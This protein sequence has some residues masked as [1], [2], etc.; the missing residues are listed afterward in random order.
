MLR[1]VRR[2]PRDDG[3]IQWD[4]SEGEI[5]GA[6]LEGVD[7]VVHL[8][9]ENLA[10]GRWTNARKKRIRSSRIDSTGPSPGPWPP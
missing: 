2:P 8:S 6:A 4:P 3:E 9:G 7:A 10:G 5:D 1:L